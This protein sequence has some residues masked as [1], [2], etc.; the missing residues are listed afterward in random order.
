MQIL[1]NGLVNGSV[2]SI[3]ALAFSLA[4]LPSGVF[5]LALGG[6]YVLAPYLLGSLRDAGCTW[7]VAAILT[8][9]ICG[10]LSAACEYCNHRPLARRGASSNAHL[11]S[12]LGLYIVFSQAAAI[13]WGNDPRTLR[14]R[15][16]SAFTVAGMLMTNSQLYELLLGVVAL[17][18]AWILLRMTRIGLNLRGLAD[19]PREMMLAGTNIWA[20]RTFAFFL[21]GVFAACASLSFAYDYGYDPNSGLTTLFIGAV[22]VMIGGRQL[23]WSPVLGGLALGVLRSEVVWFLSARWQE[24]STFA[25]LALVLVFRPNG[26]LSSARRLESQ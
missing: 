5:H 13:I 1:L 6:V 20:V 3:I 14:E 9:G 21:S 15:P 4:Y 7:V 25:V 22:A 10:A 23:F 18:A 2:I 24:A 26:L 17:A 11:V 8:L 16:D 19:N 12:S